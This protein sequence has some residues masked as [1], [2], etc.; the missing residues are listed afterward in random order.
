MANIALASLPICQES[1][2]LDKCGFPRTNFLWIWCIQNKFS[3][4]NLKYRGSFYWILCRNLPTAI[5]IFFK[6]SVVWVCWG[7]CSCITSDSCILVNGRAPESNE[8]DLFRLSF[9]LQILP[10]WIFLAQFM[11]NS[12]LIFNKKWAVTMSFKTFALKSLDMSF[13]FYR[14]VGQFPIE[15]WRQVQLK[16]WLWEDQLDIW[17][18]QM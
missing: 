10:K 11:K 1:W 16:W 8:E 15:Q 13:F 12:L 6:R 2:K 17:W 5:I 7:C 4:G 9:L 18:P 3:K 14:S